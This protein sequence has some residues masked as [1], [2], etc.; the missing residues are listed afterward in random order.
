ML[1][2]KGRTKQYS[3]TWDCRLGIVD[4]RDGL[5]RST[6][7]LTG[8]ERSLLGRRASPAHAGLRSCA[9]A[10]RGHCGVIPAAAGQAISS[11]C[12]ANLIDA[13]ALAT[14]TAASLNP[15][16]PLVKQLT[17]LVAK[18]DPEAAQFVHWGATSQDAN[19]TGLVLQIRKALDILD[20]DL[21]VLAQRSGK[22]GPAVPFH[23]DG[24]PDPDAT[25]P[26]YHFRSQ[27]CRMAGR[28]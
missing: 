11:K 12:K 9:G 6:V 21:T 20:A 24:W 18:D 22:V 4:H 19:D 15:A 8:D 7:R 1:F 23:A 10:R 3:S 26:A 5:A 16:I 25:C 27:G 2:C 14:A 13:N 28:A 17:A